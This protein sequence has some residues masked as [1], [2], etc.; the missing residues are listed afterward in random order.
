[1]PGRV[2]SGG[3]GDASSPRT[4]PLVARAST[5]CG[6]RSIRRPRSASAATS[7]TD[8]SPPLPSDAALRARILDQCVKCNGLSYADGKDLPKMLP[9]SNKSVFTHGDIAP[10]NIMVDESGRILALLDWEHAGWSCSLAMGIGR[11]GWRV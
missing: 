2:P 8:P 3:N 1:M 6:I 10:R 11:P 9:R 4:R 7:G 5:P